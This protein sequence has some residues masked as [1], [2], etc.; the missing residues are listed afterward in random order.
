MRL[1]LQLPEIY[2]RRRREWQVI[3]PCPDLPIQKVDP[4]TSACYCSNDLNHNNGPQQAIV[5]ACNIPCASNAK[6]TCGGADTISMYKQRGDSLAKREASVTP[7]DIPSNAIAKR[8]SINATL[9]AGDTYYA[10][11]GCY[12]DGTGGLNLIG[13]PV[14]YSNMTVEICLEQVCFPRK[15]FSY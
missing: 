4:E 15:Q 6:E 11:A 13:L 3:L 2:S 8:D 7:E 9:V 10:A 12:S 5:S 14:I 1:L